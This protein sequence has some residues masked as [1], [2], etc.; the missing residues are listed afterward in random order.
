MII[1]LISDL[2]DKSV[3]S[4][5]ETSTTQN[6]SIWAMVVILTL[7]LSAMVVIIKVFMSST[8]KANEGLK[9]VLQQSA[10]QLHIFRESIDKISDNFRELSENISRLQV[11]KLAEED[12]FDILSR[13]FETLKHDVSDTNSNIYKSILEQDRS[14]REFFISGEKNSDKFR[15]C[16][17]EM[18]AF[19]GVSS[20]KRKRLG[21]ILVED[22]VCSREQ[23][24]QAAKKQSA[25]E[26]E[27]EKSN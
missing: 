17:L 26:L 4:M 2:T 25:M 19:C 14:M 27:E 15:A 24:N 9:M 8:M 6:L 20:D 21:D 11:F 18:K 13:S 5:V 10:E 22:G 23:V 16:L 1:Q 12:K 3:S 7:F